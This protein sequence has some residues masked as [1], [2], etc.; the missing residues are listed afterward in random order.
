M[1]PCECTKKGRFDFCPFRLVLCKRLP[2]FQVFCMAIAYA[3]EGIV[4]SAGCCMTGPVSKPLPGGVAAPPQSPP[5]TATMC[6][7]SPAEDLGDP[8]IGLP[9]CQASD[10]AGITPPTRE[11]S[12]VPPRNLCRTVNWFVPPLRSAEVVGNLFVAVP[13]Y[14]HGLRARRLICNIMLYTC[15]SSCRFQ[16]RPPAHQFSTGHTL[17]CNIMIFSIPNPSCPPKRRRRC[18][19][20]K[21][22]RRTMS[23]S[24]LC[25][26]PTW[27][28]APK[29]RRQSPSDALATL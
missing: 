23:H 25:C 26:V 4:Q 21:H 19:A 1:A 22:F 12:L 29:K 11:K 18:K 16:Y 7:I 5:H 15:S 8:A 6:R 20:A 27:M 3:L 14:G 24:S 17:M 10:V 28:K 13:R 2:G 9:C